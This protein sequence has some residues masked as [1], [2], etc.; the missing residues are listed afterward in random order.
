MASIDISPKT[1]APYWAPYVK[2]KDCS[3]G[4]C[5]I[6][7]SQWC[8]NFPPPPPFKFETDDSSNSN[9]SPLVIAIIGILASAFLLITYYTIVSKYCGN[10]DSLR[11]RLQSNPNEEI[12]ESLSPSQRYDQWQIVTTGLDETLIKSITV[13][14]YKKGD[15]LVEG[16]E[17]SVCLIEFHEDESL[18]LLP[19]CSHAFH[20]PCIDM[21]LNS[22][23]NC[24]L[25]RAGI[26]STSPLPAQLPAPVPE[27]L[28]GHGSLDSQHENDMVVAI[29]DLERG[30]EENSLGNAV[31]SKRSFRALS[32][33]EE[34]NSIIEIRDNGIQPIRRSVSMD[35]TSR[36]RILIADVL[37]MS[38]EE[39]I[40]EEDKSIAAGAESESESSQRCGGEGSRGNDSSGV[41]HSVLS[42]TLMKRSSS[43]GRFMFT[44]H[45]RGSN[46]VIPI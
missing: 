16:T 17:C 33:L 25:C 14:K 46:A 38:V 1:W 27:S 35:A 5:T 34:R 21:W 40:Q 26:V 3:Q 30:G 29:E 7:C 6:F 9:F 23:S 42:L 4:V 10:F 39:G 13:C 2:P 11:R 20:I 36:G 32:N 15:G 8:S 41:L 19:K 28:S 22:H 24:P 44:R 37:G 12:D 31:A 45:G 18:R 43:N